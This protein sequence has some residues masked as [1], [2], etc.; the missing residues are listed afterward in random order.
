MI[1][2]GSGRHHYFRKGRAH[3]NHGC[4]DDDFRHVETLCQIGGAVYKPVAALDEQN[5]AYCEKTQCAGKILADVV[6]PLTD[7][8]KH[9]TLN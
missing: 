1:D 5:Q 2:G 7:G 3:G 8:I 4:T 9:T 6:Q